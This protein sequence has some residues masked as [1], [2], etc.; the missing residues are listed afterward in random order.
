MADVSNQ[1]E[2]IGLM[3]GELN[4][5]GQPVLI[6]ELFFSK[7]FDVVLVVLHTFFI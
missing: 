3:K 4:G 6:I 5:G 1:R 2:T 7:T